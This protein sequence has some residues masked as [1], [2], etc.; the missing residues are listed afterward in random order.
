VN[1]IKLSIRI[2]LICSILTTFSFSEIHKGRKIYVENL[3]KVCAM[4]S[5]LF[6]S[7]HSQ[8]EWEDIYDAGEFVNEVKKICP[9]MTSEYETKWTEMLY[10][11]SY[12]Y[13]NDS[14]SVPSC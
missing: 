6:A 12:Q 5:L 1:V 3:K 8:D 10:N 2:I 9:N 7:T 14:E 11:F 13:A 4:S